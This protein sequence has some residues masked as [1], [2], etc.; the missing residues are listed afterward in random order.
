MSMGLSPPSVLPPRPHMHTLIYPAAGPSGRAQS[1]W[2]SPFFLRYQ[3]VRKRRCTLLMAHP[4]LTE[5][6]SVGGLLLQ[7]MLHRLKRC[8]KRWRHDKRFYWFPSS[9]GISSTIFGLPSR[10][11]WGVPEALYV[12]CQPRILP[13]VIKYSSNLFGR[14]KS[15]LEIFQSFRKNLEFPGWGPKTNTDQVLM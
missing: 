12:N 15:H 7:C 2:R 9:Y 11:L 13:R 3:V 5:V 4:P 6:I 10:H 14:F 1:L 8:P